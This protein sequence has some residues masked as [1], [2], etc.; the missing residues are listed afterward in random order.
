LRTQTT[1]YCSYS[2]VEPANKLVRLHTHKD[3]IVFLYDVCGVFEVLLCFFLPKSSKQ[4]WRSIM[5][6]SHM[7]VCNSLT[8]KQY[9]SHWRPTLCCAAHHRLPSPHAPLSP[10]H[11]SAPQTASIAPDRPWSR[12]EVSVYAPVHT[13]KYLSVSLD[14]RF[15]CLAV[16]CASPRTRLY[17]GVVSSADVHSV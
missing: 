11:S 9:I 13:Y 17:T 12:Q 6:G 4:L 8:L 15:K 7:Q 14:Q 16:Y 5:L 10:A 3:S 1:Y 2:E